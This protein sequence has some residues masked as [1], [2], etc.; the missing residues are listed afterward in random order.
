MDLF[1]LFATKLELSVCN[2]SMIIKGH[3]IRDK[4]RKTSRLLQILIFA[5]SPVAIR[6][7][8]VCSQDSNPKDNHVQ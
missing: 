7:R 3:A 4:V 2:Q 5:L 6:K 8:F 1:G